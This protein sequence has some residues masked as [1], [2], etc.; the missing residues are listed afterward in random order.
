VAWHLARFIEHVRSVPADP[1]VLR[2]NWLRAYAYVAGQ[3]VPAP[4][5]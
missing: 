1:V 5:D 3:G 2:Q 4:N